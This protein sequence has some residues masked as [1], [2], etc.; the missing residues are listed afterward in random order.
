M[1]VAA[2][3]IDVKKTRPFLISG[4]VTAVVMVTISLFIPDRAQSI[5]TLCVG[6][7]A[8]VTIA[9]IPIYDIPS[10]SLLQRSLLHFGVIAVTVL[11]LVLVSGWFSAP[12]SVLVFLLFGVVGWT[13]G[14]L[15]HRRRERVRT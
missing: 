15:L 1:T 13:V 12:V 14:Y 9:A 6:L 10:W 2:S 4:A 7:I 8:G 11:P 3:L 5:S